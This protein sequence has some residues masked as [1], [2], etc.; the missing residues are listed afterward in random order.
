MRN[1]SILDF[2]FWIAEIKLIAHSKKLIFSY[3]DAI[4]YQAFKFSRFPASKPLIYELSAIRLKHPAASKPQIAP[5]NTQH[6]I[7]QPVMRNP[8]PTHLKLHP[9]VY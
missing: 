6:A 9:L 8:Q 2:R 5:R 3:Y 4:S 7:P 1:D